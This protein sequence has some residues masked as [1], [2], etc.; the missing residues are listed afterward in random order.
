MAEQCMPL[1]C[2]NLR[3][4]V[5][6]DTNCATFIVQVDDSNQENN[7]IEASAFTELCIDLGGGTV[8]TA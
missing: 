1:H 4:D 5:D 3:V 6:D 2:L 7:Q 8:G